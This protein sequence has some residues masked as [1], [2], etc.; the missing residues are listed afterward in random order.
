MTLAGQHGFVSLLKVAVADG[1]LSI[2]R[3]QRLPKRSCPGSGAITN[4]H[5]DNLTGI[6]VDGEPN[7]LFVAFVA[8]QG[9]SLVT[10]HRQVPFF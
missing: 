1:A 3:R 5:P 6:A 9:P 8:D 7:P 4:M 10:G 2:N